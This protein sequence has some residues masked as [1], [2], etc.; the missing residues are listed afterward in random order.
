MIQ[1][2]R[3]RQTEAVFL[4]ES[5][6]GFPAD[7]LKRARRKLQVLDAATD[8][9]DLRDPPGNRLHQLVEDREGQWSISVN[10]QFRIC[11]EWG[12]A[13][14]ENVEFTDYH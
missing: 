10:G 9:T 3:N 1:T 13:G 11:F 5:P 8:V 6:K 2:F 12:P 14:P 7:L 4:G